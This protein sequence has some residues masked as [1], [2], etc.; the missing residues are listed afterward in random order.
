MWHGTVAGTVL[1]DA[2]ME[3]GTLL[4][5]ARARSF[6]PWST[7]TGATDPGIR[8]AGHGASMSRSTVHT[9][10]I[11]IGLAEHSTRSAVHFCLREQQLQHRT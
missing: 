2:T 7:R 9:S 10:G 1:E 3:A 4:F 8:F 11:I 5:L 6:S